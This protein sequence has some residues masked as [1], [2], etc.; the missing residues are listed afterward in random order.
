MVSI[1]PPAVWTGCAE[2]ALPGADQLEERAGWWYHRL[3][4]GDIP[5]GAEAWQVHE[6]PERG[7]VPADDVHGRC[8]TCHHRAD[9]STGGADKNKDVLQCV[10]DELFP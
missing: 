2:F 3:C 4:G 9:G 8:D 10:G 6:L 1:L 5:R 7:Y